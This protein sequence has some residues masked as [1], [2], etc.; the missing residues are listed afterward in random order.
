MAR[1][2][3]PLRMAPDRIQ[4]QTSVLSAGVGIIRWYEKRRGIA[5]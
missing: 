1:E 2:M 4:E 5:R 3:Q